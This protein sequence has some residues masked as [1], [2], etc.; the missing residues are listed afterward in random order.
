MTS[1]L[2]DAAGE[3]GGR[4]MET[5]A[6]RRRGRRAS[7]GATPAFDPAP[8]SASALAR[9][10]RLWTVRA[11]AEHESALIFTGLLPFA[12]EAGADLDTQAVIVGMAEDELRHAVICADVARR[13]GGAPVAAPATAIPRSARP[14]AEQFLK[15]VVYGNCMTETV[16]VARLVD[17]SE[18][19]R[20]PVL[21]QALRA[22]LS[23]E[24]RHA[25][26]GF[27]LLADWA[28]WLAAHPEAR[29]AI[30]QFLPQAFAGLE[31]TLSGVGA[32]SDGFGADDLAL[33]SPDPARLPEVF[34]RTVEEAVIPG[35]ERAGFAAGAAW[36]ARS[37]AP[38]R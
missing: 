30:D 22:L 8:Y 29:Q 18:G 31:R 4:W 5:E 35:L 38:V 11:A 21:Q 34:F 15:H 32:P 23:D 33:G 28:P 10:K 16:N 36:R 17:A 26:F 7:G 1:D 12:L 20:D 27:A 24:V 13:L 2:P 37:A 19:A 3:G 6:Q 14:V 9:A 25:R